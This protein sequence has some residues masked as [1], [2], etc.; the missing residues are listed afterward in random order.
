MREVD[1]AF[2]TLQYPS[3]G[4]LEDA[5]LSA[6]ETSS[7]VTTPI[8]TPAGFDAAWLTSRSLRKAKIPIA[9]EPPPTQAAT[10]SGKRPSFSNIWRRHSSPITLE[11]A[12]HQEGMRTKGRTNV[13]SRQ[14]L[15]TQSRM[16]SLTAG[17]S[18]LQSHC[19]FG[20]TE[21]HAVDVE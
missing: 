17:V 19:A 2:W 7:M 13:A 4:S 18:A 9:F 15:V 6:F 14:A 16:A 5:E 12:N 1:L 21:T 11:V 8:I 3:L 20:T 10:S